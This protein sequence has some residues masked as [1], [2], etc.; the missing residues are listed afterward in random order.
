MAE[1]HADQLPP[2]SLDLASEAGALKDMQARARALA[3]V[4]RTLQAEATSA[5]V[6]R[7]WADP[8]YRE[9]ISAQ[10]K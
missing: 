3:K 9:R 6:A 5:A 1:R 4:L 7:L 10:F 2:D 8:A